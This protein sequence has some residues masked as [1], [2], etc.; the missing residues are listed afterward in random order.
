Y[1]EKSLVFRRFLDMRYVGQ[2]FE[3]IVEVAADQLTSESISRAERDFED[4]HE[5]QHGHRTLGDTRFEIVNVRVT[6]KMPGDNTRDRF[7][8]VPAN[9]SE[10]SAGIQ[11]RPV[12]FGPSFG[13]HDT[14]VLR[15]PDL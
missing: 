15:R 4:A 11:T 1:P 12:Y 10:S 13:W 3:L 5:Q 8:G 6:G 7:R 9:M 2:A 14:P